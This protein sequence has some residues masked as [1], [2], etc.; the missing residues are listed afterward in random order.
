M[1]IEDTMKRINKKF[2]DNAIMLL[3]QKFIVQVPALSTGI[4]PLDVALGVGGL[5]RGRIIELYGPESSGKTTIC[6][7]VIAEA[8]KN[9]EKCA[10][11]DNENAIDCEWARK[12]GVN[13]DDL[14][15]S[16]PDSGED[17]LSIAEML[18]EDKVSV[19]VVDSVAALVPRAELE[20]Q[21][22]DA[23]VG[24]Q[25]RL[26]SQALRKLT[27]KVRA[28]G[29]ILIFTNQIREKIGIKWGDPTTTSGGR[30]LK[31]YT[32]VR[33]QT[34]RYA[35]IN[36]KGTVE[37]EGE[38]GSKNAI[39]STIGIKIVKNKVAPPFKYT[40]AYLL[41]DK[42]FDKA[43]NVVELA[44][45]NKLIEKRGAWFDFEGQA[46]QGKNNLIEAIRDNKNLLDKLTLEVTKALLPKEEI[47]EETN[48]ERFQRKLEKA[49]EDND[50]ER[51]KKYTRLVEK[52]INNV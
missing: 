45:T 10:I 4:L 37:E 30:A 16:Q 48:L 41:F 34:A 22:G 12:L 11:V 18:I 15:V 23:H 47:E 3:G 20:G 39:G 43:Y 19:I 33:I 8:Q 2:G 44:L 46:Y 49:K 17:S 35:N 21:I 9:S 32:S 6:L 40:Q 26:M 31:F 13:T 25:A 7:N 5:P 28:S 36:E 38:T 29:S 50:E 24:L 42:G 14:M 1:D 51:I 52:E 27:S